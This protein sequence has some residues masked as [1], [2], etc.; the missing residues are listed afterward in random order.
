[1]WIARRGK[2]LTVWSVTATAE[3]GAAA[4]WVT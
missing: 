2:D 4:A 3:A 1:M